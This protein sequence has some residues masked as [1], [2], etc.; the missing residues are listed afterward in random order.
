MLLPAV[1]DFLRGIEGIV[2][3]AV[4]GRV[5]A[6][7]ANPL[8]ACQGSA[9]TY[10]LLRWPAYDWSTI[11][12]TKGPLEFS[13]FNRVKPAI[14]L[15]CLSTT[16]EANQEKSLGVETRANIGGRGALPQN[17]LFLRRETLLGP[18]RSFSRFGA[19]IGVLLDL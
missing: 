3:T 17:Y 10:E 13:A 14:A 2:P 8:R 5:P 15:D 9:P 12:L 1:H 18:T 11:L 6:P 16:C 19:G 7:M 4:G